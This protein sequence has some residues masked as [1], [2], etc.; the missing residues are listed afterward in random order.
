L[1]ERENLLMQK[2]GMSEFLK[3]Q[4]DEMGDDSFHFNDSIAIDD[5]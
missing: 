4:K 3:F 5:N 2:I 1:K